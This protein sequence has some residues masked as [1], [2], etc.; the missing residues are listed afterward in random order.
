MSWDP[1]TSRVGKYLK[2]CDKM[3]EGSTSN[4]QSQVEHSKT[5]NTT[6]LYP[7]ASQLPTGREK[8]RERERESLGHSSIFYSLRVLHI[9]NLQCFRSFYFHHWSFRPRNGMQKLRLP[10]Y[11]LYYGSMNTPRI[12]TSKAIYLVS[13]ARLVPLI[14]VWP[15]R[16]SAKGS[17][18]ATAGLIW[19]PRNLLSM[20]H[21]IPES[22]FQIR[23]SRIPYPGI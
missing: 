16:L 18:A 10:T 23:Y 15:P 1:I 14:F 5:T 22:R 6:W 17:L 9:S 21:L 19:S 20:H 7:S 2:S 8:E 11:H 13:D 3:G 4:H 12:N